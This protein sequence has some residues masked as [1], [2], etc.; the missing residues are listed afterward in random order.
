MGNATRVLV[1]ATG[2][3]A[4]CGTASL[5]AASL[6]D[7][8]QR[9]TSPLRYPGAPKAPNDDPHSPYAMNYMDEAAQ[10]LG[11]RDGQMDLFSTRPVAHNPLVPVVSGGLG[12]DG[13]MLKLQWHP[14]L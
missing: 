11:V 10:T 9:L 6:A 3:L 5:A 1:L 14:G 4:L 2:I 7:D 12:G 13:A 8:N